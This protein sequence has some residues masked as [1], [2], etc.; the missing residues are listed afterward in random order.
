MVTRAA[1]PNSLPSSDH[2]S[3]QL[4]HAL[5][6]EQIDV[7]VV[8]QLVCFDVEFPHEFAHLAHAGLRGFVVSQHNLEFKEITQSSSAS[9][10]AFAARVSTLSTC[11]L[12]SMLRDI[13]LG[14]SR[15]G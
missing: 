1:I 11:A 7:G 15:C 9:E 8:D 14:V 5:S 3:N 6:C 4:S 13:F 2:G 10:A 12:I